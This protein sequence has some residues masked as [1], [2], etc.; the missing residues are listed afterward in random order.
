MVPAIICC[1]GSLLKLVGEPP[2]ELVDKTGLGLVLPARVGRGQDQQSGTVF[3]FGIHGRRFHG[4]SG[5][6]V[7]ESSIESR[8]R[9]PP[10]IRLDVD[11]CIPNW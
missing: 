7:P 1:A 10:R 9:F 6:R 2:R 4:F 11:K 5:M 8:T 3:R